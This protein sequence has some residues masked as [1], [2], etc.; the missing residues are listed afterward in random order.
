MPAEEASQLAVE[1]AINYH[2]KIKTE[3]AEVQWNLPLCITWENWPFLTF[4]NFFCIFS[5]SLKVCRMG[6]YHNVL[7]IALKVSWEWGVKDSGT[8]CSLLNE[9]YSCEKTFERLFLG[10]I[11]GSHAPYFIAGWRSDFRDQVS[12]T[13]KYFLRQS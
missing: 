9:I 3:N 10:S 8:I 12:G 4:I 11:F 2:K 6:K 5:I 13:I 1:S 7:Y